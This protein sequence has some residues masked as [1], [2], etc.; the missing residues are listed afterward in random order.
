MGDVLDRLWELARSSE[1][2]APF[3]RFRAKVSP[4]EFVFIGVLLYT[5]RHGYTAAEQSRA[6]FVLRRDI[7]KAHVDVRFNARVAADCWRL[8]DSIE[9]GEID[10]EPPMA[11]EL[12]SSTTPGVN[13]RK[14]KSYDYTQ[15]PAARL[16]R[17]RGKKTRDVY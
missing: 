8:I 14:R 9:N 3:R 1:H 2:D 15:P 6:A 16:Q 17:T 10:I 5:M 7:R 12:P 4:V 11:S 13:R